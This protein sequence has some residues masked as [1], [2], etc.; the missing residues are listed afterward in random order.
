MDARSEDPSDPA[1][2][3]RVITIGRM[4][5]Y[6]QQ[7]VTQFEPFVGDGRHHPALPRTAGPDQ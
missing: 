1:V 3:T 7:V 2:T 4:S 5:D 6:W